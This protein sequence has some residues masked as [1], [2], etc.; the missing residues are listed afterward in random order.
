MK[1]FICLMLLSFYLISSLFSQSADV[2]IFFK[3]NPIDFENQCVRGEPESIINQD[4]FR[5]EFRIENHVGFEKLILDSVTTLIIK[6]HGCESYSLTFRFEILEK[7]QKLDNIRFWYKRLVG[8]MTKI[9]D[10]NQS[11]IDIFE[12]IKALVKYIDVYSNEPLKLG[13]YLY[14]SQG[15]IPNIV[16]FDQIKELENNKFVLEATTWIGPL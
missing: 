8:L 3:T 14:I 5:T 6:N 15:E 13:H 7:N 11:P 9:E 1:S 4:K 12:L 16:V 2:D 10:A